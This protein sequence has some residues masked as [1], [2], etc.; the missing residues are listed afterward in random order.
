MN[1]MSVYENP[2]FYQDVIKPNFRTQLIEH[3]P[4][5]PGSMVING[6][7]NDQLFAGGFQP[8]ATR[9]A[10]QGHRSWRSDP[11]GLIEFLTDMADRDFALWFYDIMSANI[12][13]TGLPIV[14]Y[15][16]FW[17][18]WFFNHMWL[19][20]A[21]PLPHSSLAWFANHDY[22]QW[23]LHHNLAQARSGE[24]VGYKQEAKDYIYSVWPDAY[25]HAF[26]TKYH[27]GS[28]ASSLRDHVVLQPEQRGVWAL[29]DD[30]TY[31][32][33]DQSAWARDLVLDHVNI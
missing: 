14:T 3:A 30:G 1:S 12:L 19:S 20:V 6:H 7:P 9:F 13:S 18:W 32:Q 29:L 28:L 26:K 8:F 10:T 15:S 16:Q 21:S 4:A 17:W 2:R 23:S 31:L 25:Y 24:H 11:D 33:G 22:Q 5:S 27:S